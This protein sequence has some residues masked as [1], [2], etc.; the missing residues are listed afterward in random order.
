MVSAPPSPNS[1]ERWGT[2]IAVNS[3]V[4][5]VWRRGVAGCQAEVVSRR[6]VS[7][8]RAHLCSAAGCPAREAR[9]LPAL[10]LAA[11]CPAAAAGPGPDWLAGDYL[12]PSVR[13]AVGPRAVA[14]LMA[15]AA[16]RHR[17]DSKP[18]APMVLPAEARHP[19]RV[20]RSRCRRV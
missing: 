4:V 18:P 11:D 14:D 8:W 20:R 13:P 6:L 10:P 3:W 1:G 9:P 12:A 17:S 15:A 5:L 7:C 2:V 16:S 19:S